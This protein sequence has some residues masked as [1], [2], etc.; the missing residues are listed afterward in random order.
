L[1]IGASLRA[2][3]VPIGGVFLF[4][5]AGPATNAV[6]MS[7]V[8]EMFGKRGFFIYISTIMVLSLFFGYIL[9]R[10]F[11]NFE[12]RDYFYESVSAGALEYLATTLM[13][14]L[15]IYHWRR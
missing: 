4:L 11:I 8:K 13:F 12:I 2:S 7:V 14:G 5:S 3:G 6:T 1:P 10:V 15:M 9:D